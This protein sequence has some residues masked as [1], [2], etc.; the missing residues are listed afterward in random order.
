METYTFW[1]E[2]EAR[3]TRLAEAGGAVDL[4]AIRVELDLAAVL[5]E[6]A[7][8]MLQAIKNPAATPE[9]VYHHARTT[10]RAGRILNDGEQADRWT[11]SGGPKIEVARAALRTAITIEAKIAATGAGEAHV[12]MSEQALLEAWLDLI[13]RTKNPRWREFQVLEHVAL[14]SAEMCN[15]LAGEAYRNDVARRREAPVTAPEPIEPPSKAQQRRDAVLPALKR[16]GLSRAQWAD[17]AG[18]DPGVAYD[19]LAGK[20]N[21]SPNSHRKLTKV[22]GLPDLPE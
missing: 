2:R 19:Y 16:L 14:A 3:F 17:K 4:H 13:A 18:V 9:S 20:S 12:G 22:L 15:Q 7:D 6:S 1:R 11:L 21:L 5:D 8:R 10:A